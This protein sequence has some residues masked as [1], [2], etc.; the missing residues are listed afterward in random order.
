L[1]EEG[2]TAHLYPKIIGAETNS[3][4]ESIH[5]RKKINIDVPLKAWKMK[6]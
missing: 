3:T 2:T 4:S 1:N 6:D 5:G